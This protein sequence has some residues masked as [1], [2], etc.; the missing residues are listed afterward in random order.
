MCGDDGRKGRSKEGKGKGKRGN[1]RRGSRG[2]GGDDSDDDGDD[3]SRKA[4]IRVQ[5]LGRKLNK[6][7]RGVDD[8]LNHITDGLGHISGGLG[9]LSQ[10]IQRGG[11]G[12]GRQYQGGGLGGAFNDNKSY[13]DDDPGG[14][15]PS[16]RRDPRGARIFGRGPGYSLQRLGMVRNGSNLFDSS[17][18]PAYGAYGGMERTRGNGTQSRERNGRG[19]R[20]GGRHIPGGKILRNPM[21]GGGYEDDSQFTMHGGRNSMPHDLDGGLNDADPEPNDNWTDIDV[22]SIHAELPQHRRASPPGRPRRPGPSRH[23]STQS[24]VQRGGVPLRNAYT[25]DASESI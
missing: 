13:G 8:R 22:G 10:A 14:I 20:R 3:G 15:R 5:K 11:N 6:G 17:E 18:M 12:R 19:G 4:T 16:N 25:E 24:R 7:L 21:P 23:Q 9:Q 2:R 1:G